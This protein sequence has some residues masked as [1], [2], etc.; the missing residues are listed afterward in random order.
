MRARWNRLSEQYQAALGK[1]LKQ[2]ARSVPGSAA[3]LG[4]R[5]LALGLGTLD[6]A[7]MH[8]RAMGAVAAA[9]DSG[10]ARDGLFKRV[11]AFFVAAIGPIEQ[12]HDVAMESSVRLQPVSQALR[13]RTEALASA[14]AQLQEE[15]QRRQAAEAS[16]RKSR[17]H[18]RLLLDRSRLMQEQL[19]QLSRRILLAQEEERK[20]ISRELHD[21]IAQTLSAINVHLETLSREAAVS[22]QGLRQ[23]IKRTQRL[24]TRSVDIVHRFA[25]QLRPTLLDDLGL[26]PALHALLKEF[27][28][29]TG[30]RG[31]LTAFAEVEQLSGMKRTVLYR[32]AQA[33]LTNVAE[34][35]QATRVR[36]RIQKPGGVVR[37]EIVDDGKGFDMERV[38]L[39]RGRKRLGLLGMRER[40][41][42]VGGRFA[43][44]SAPG[45]G[46]TL[47]TEIPFDNGARA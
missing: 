46:T 34:H 19:R 32:V 22:N 6:L 12:I 3:G 1:H 25:R 37:M 28:K 26:I 20:E 2:G 42:M 21:D 35:A 30:V 41:E 24:V 8:G 39:A 31:G 18:Y 27:T 4:R 13:Q 38:L 36:V 45:R 43:V 17:L 15:I 44:E 33:A 10:S 29:R 47:R 7:R 16:L 11:Q 23:K 40:V 5:A 9:R 14:N